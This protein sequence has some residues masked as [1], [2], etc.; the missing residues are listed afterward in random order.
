[1]S[2][3]QPKYETGGIYAALAAAQGEIGGAK[4]DAKNPHFK[5]QYATLESVVDAIKPVAAKHGL[6]Y[7]QRFHDCENGVALETIIFH[8]S[9]AELSTGTLR[10]PASKNDAQGYGSAITYARRYGLQTAFG[11][12]PEDDDGNAA[13][14]AE[15]KESKVITVQQAADLRALMQ[16]VGAD[17][18]KFLAYFQNGTIEELPAGKYGQAIKLLQAKRGK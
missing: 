11:I 5:S 14:K 3:E 6:G 15:P 17:E 8:A 4:K 9:G 16:E 18:G 13:V 10:I 2:E 7:L 12:A 1:M